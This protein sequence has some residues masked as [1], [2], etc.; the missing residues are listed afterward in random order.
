M[1]RARNQGA[2]P[3]QGLTDGQVT[4]FLRRNPDF[5]AR[6]PQL[7]SALVPPARDLQG[8]EDGSVADLQQYMLARLREQVRRMDEQHEELIETSRTN[9]HIQSRVHAAVLALLA[10]RG[11]DNL[12]DVVTTDLG[13]LLDV[14]VVVLCVECGEVPRV[15]SEGIRVIPGGTIDGLLGKRARVLLRA[16][17]S[18]DR[19]VYGQAAGLVRSDA[20]VRLKVRNGHPDGLLALGAREVNTFQPGQGTELLGFLARVLEHSIRT[21]LDL[22]R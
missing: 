13:L 7:F 14:D 8:T 22:P 21:W 15:T 19:E 6:H 9:L 10:A 5:L 2:P 16:N 18:G 4:A 11:I 3:P 17:T 12:M 1:S 20:L